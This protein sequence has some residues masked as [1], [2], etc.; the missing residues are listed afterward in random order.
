MA[1][2]L[3]YSDALEKLLKQQGEHALALSRA[4]EEAQRWCSKWNT[5]LQLPTIILSS[6]TGFFSAA[7]DMVPQMALGGVSITVAIIGSIQSYLSFAKRSEAHRNTAL[8]YARIH[9]ILS[10]ELSLPR[11]ER[12]PAYKLLETLKTEAET[13]TE[14][15]PILPEAIKGAFKLQFKDLAGFS[16]P[17]ALNGLDPISI[18]PEPLVAAPAPERPTIRIVV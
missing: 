15:S 12:T 18:A 7:P 1:T 4:H 11:A 16:F 14:T 13:L 17:P 6:L 8:N 3:H 5:R 9:R 10:T 2:E